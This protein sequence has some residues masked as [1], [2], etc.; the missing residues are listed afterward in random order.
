M[1]EGSDRNPSGASTNTPSSEE[2]AK[3]YFTDRGG[4]YVDVR[5]LLNSKDVREEIE[6]MTRFPDS[7]QQ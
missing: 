3:V 6:R 2:P 4:R 5:E 1:P 7:D